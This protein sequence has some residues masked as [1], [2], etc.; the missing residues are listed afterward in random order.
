MVVGSN[1]TR[2]SCG[3]SSVWIEHVVVFA[4]LVA[5]M[6]LSS[7]GQD[8]RL[9]TWGAEFDSPQARPRDRRPAAGRRPPMPETRV[10]LPSIA[11]ANAGE[12]TS[13]ISSNLVRR[14]CA[15]IAQSVE[16]CVS[17]PLVADLSSLHLPRQRRGAHR[18][19]AFP[20]KE[21]LIGSTPMRSIVLPR[22][23]SGDAARLSPE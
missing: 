1:P 23:A 8:P 10:Q 6:C 2:R 9:S 13:V 12:T 21:G 15:A 17:S 16:Q 14:L 18:G 20:C 19:G 5:A 22:C 7:S 11:S 4:R 3:G